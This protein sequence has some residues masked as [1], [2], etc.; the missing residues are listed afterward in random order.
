MKAIYLIHT[1]G[2]PPEWFGVGCPTTLSDLILERDGL[3][4]ILGIYELEKSGRMQLDYNL[5]NVTEDA[6]KIVW[7][8]FDP[9][10]QESPG[11]FVEQFYPDWEA[12]LADDR[13]ETAA[14]RR[15][16]ENYRQPY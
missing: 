12:E 11:R 13:R 6:A 4:D 10:G 3:D 1:A 5:N 9:L 16:Q 7:D 2:D 14:M 15:H 8:F